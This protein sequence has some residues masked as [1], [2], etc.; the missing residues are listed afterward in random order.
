MLKNYFFLNLFVLLLGMTFGGVAIQPTMAVNDYTPTVTEDEISV[1]LETSFDNAKVWAWNDQ[2]QLTVAGWPGDAMTL[3]GKTAN[4]KNIFKWTYTGDKGAPTE[5]IFTHDGEQKLNGGDQKFVNHG[6]Y[7]EGKYTK[8]IEVD[9]G[10]VMVFFDNTTA[11]LDDVYCF[12]YNG[13]TA[14][15]QWPG[16][17]MAYD[18]KA[19]FNG[20]TGYYTV[21]VPNNF[22]TGMF[23]INNGKD[24]KT[25]Q[26]QTV[27]VGE[28][29]SAIE[30]VTMEETKSNAE[31]AWYTI[32]GIRINKPTQAGLYIHNGKK[33]I[34]R[35]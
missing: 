11:N 18:S 14:A 28:T 24:G 2:P 17:K 27:Y 19:S 22:L 16:M 34:I 31:D 33:V 15:Q 6:Y 8:T 21:E 26:G 12:I 5:I 25:L 29:T 20:K 4:G 13:T 9:A 35:K 23:V 1:F 7:V 30:N 10:K 32:T 3:M